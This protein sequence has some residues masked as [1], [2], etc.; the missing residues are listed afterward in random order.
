MF[1]EYSRRFSHLYAA[2]VK[3]I[4]DFVICTKSTH[5]WDTLHQ[6]V[7]GAKF[8]YTINLACPQISD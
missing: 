1:Q 6:K 3:N 8:S 2:A 4:K 5:W 7:F